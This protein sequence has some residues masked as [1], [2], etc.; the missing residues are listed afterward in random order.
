MDNKDSEPIKVII[1]P[2]GYIEAAGHPKCFK[3]K[4]MK[5][6]DK[7]GYIVRVMT[8]K[9]YKELPNKWVFDKQA[10]TSLPH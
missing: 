1:D 4:D 10:S 3:A 6:Y 7:P 5:L 9:E 8:F 2:D